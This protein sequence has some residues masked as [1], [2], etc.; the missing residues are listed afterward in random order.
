MILAKRRVRHAHPSQRVPLVQE[1]ELSHFYCPQPLALGNAAQCQE[2]FLTVQ[3]NLPLFLMEVGGIGLGSA[4][5]F[6]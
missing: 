2:A 3:R 1:S 6:P 4:G 5:S